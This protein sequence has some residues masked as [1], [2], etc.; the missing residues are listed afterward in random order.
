MHKLT[1]A[2]VHFSSTGSPIQSDVEQLCHSLYNG[3]DTVLVE[4]NAFGSWR[5]TQLTRRILC[6]CCNCM[7]V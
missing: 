1:A 4:R 6:V 2:S 5:E 7:Y 3:K